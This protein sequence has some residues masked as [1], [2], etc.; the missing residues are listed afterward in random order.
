MYASPPDYQ[1]NSHYIGCVVGRV[2]NRIK[3]GSFVLDGKE[4]HLTPNE[5]P[6]HL[7]GGT[8]GFN[9]V[10]CTTRSS[11]CSCILYPLWL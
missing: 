1:T 7:H 3:G 6:N 4:H 5:P 9:K 8:A 11:S 2:T 10:C